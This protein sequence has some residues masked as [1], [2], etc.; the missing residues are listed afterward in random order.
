MAH[1]GRRPKRRRHFIK[2]SSTGILV[3]GFLH[4]H[5]YFFFRI[6]VALRCPV[7]LLHRLASC[8]VCCF[9]RFDQRH[10]RGW[11]HGVEGRYIDVPSSP[12]LDESFGISICADDLTSVRNTASCIAR[13][14]LG[15]ILHQEAESRSGPVNQPAAV[16]ECRTQIEASGS[17]LIQVIPGVIGDQNHAS[18]GF[19][20]T[21]VGNCQTPY[22][23]PLQHT[24]HTDMPGI[25]DACMH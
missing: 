4:H 11:I 25:I 1:R 2:S 3:S 23:W 9:S 22:Q 5:T 10:L 20:G 12:V 6:V 21:E 13:V 14:S 7:A 8:A 19:I 24:I 15:G 17:Q 18:G 16:L